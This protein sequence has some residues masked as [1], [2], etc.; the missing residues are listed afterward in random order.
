VDLSNQRL[1]ILAM[2][3]LRLLKLP[4]A[5]VPLAMSC[6]ALV[7]VLVHLCLSGITREP[8]EGPAAHIFQIL[9]F[10]QLPLAAVF[11]RRF[12]P[13]APKG[14][15]TIIGLQAFAV[16]IAIFPVWWLRL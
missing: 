11:A 13:R 16:V 5:F 4:G 2:S 3:F 7:V 6:T 15:V 9:I 14:T 8:D 12:L 10:A 1:G